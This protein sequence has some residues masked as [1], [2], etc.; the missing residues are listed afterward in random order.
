MISQKRGSRASIL[1]ATGER[2]PRERRELAG[3]WENVRP[4]ADEEI[5]H[6]VLADGEERE[7]RPPRPLVPRVFQ[8]T[9]STLSSLPSGPVLFSFPAL[10]GT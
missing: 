3:F 5:R 6:G 8:P 7:L 1:P 9:G 10:R 4:F 2:G